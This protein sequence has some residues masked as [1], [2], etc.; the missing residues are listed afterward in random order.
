MC[1]IN[2]FWGP[3][4]RELLE[5]MMIVQRHRGP[6]DDGFLEHDVASLGFRRLSII[7]IAHGAQPMTTADGHLHIVYNG[8]VYNF[9]ELRVDLE[10]RGHE[11][12]TTCDTEVVLHAYAEWGL[13]CLKK[14]NGMWGFAVLDLRG[15]SPKLV[16]ARDHYGIKPLYYATSGQRILFASEIK[17]IL[18]DD[19][20][21][22]EV[23]EEQLYQY[24]LQG[25]FDHTESTFFKGVRQ[26]PAAGYVVIQDSGMEEGKYWEPVL[27]ENGSGD[28]A[29]FRAVFERSVQRRLIADVPVGICLSGGLDSSSICT[30]M[31]QQ[32]EAHIPDSRSLGDRLKTF[33][34]LFPNDPIDEKDYLDTVLEKTGA[35]SSTCEPT[36][37]DFIEQMEDWVW[38][39]EQPMVSSAPFAMWMVMRLASEQVTVVLDG[40][41][42]DELLGGYDHYPYV[43]LRQ[44]WS[45]GE[46]RKLA[47]ETWALRDIVWPLVRRRLLERRHKAPVKSWLKSDF[48]QGKQ[49]A[50][51]P[52]VLNNLKLRL[53]Q[54]F[55]IYSLPPLLRYEDR[56]SMAHSIEARL[57]FLDQE[58]VEHVLNLPTEAIISGG[59]TRRILREALKGTLPDKVYRRRK[60]I[61]FTTPEF[62]WYRRRRATL[63]SLMR[64]PSFANRQYWNAGPIAEAFRQACA[65]EIEESMFFWRVINAEIWLRIFFD[66]HVRRPSELSLERGFSGRGDRSVA[67]ANEYASDLLQRCRANEGHHLFLQAGSDV[68]ARIPM[69][70][71]VVG[72][73][74]D[75]ISEISTCLDALGARGV[76]VE[77]GDLLLVSEKTVS[78]SQGRSF[79]VVEVQVGRLARLLSRFVGRF[80]TGVGLAH[81]VTTQLAI[82]EAGAPRILA[83]AL[84][85]A[86]TRP[87]GVH[88]LFYRVAGNRVNAID[89]PSK[90][91]LPPYDKWASL[92]PLDCEGEAR[93]LA[94]GL[95]ERYGKRVEVAII[96]ASDLGADVFAHTS[97]VDQ[98]TVLA[99]IADNPLGQSDEQTPFGLVRKMPVGAGSRVLT[100]A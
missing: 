58:L 77:D 76:E 54:D 73:G 34:A 18:Q 95:R 81:P 25:F 8:E 86:V 64:S 29:E 45:G 4:D 48:V 88:G 36:A 2:G 69:R 60:K 56:A 68:F 3:R 41:G 52:R 59:W 91:N 62:R 26:V 6:D 22:R 53:L 13:D 31:A 72:V 55:L 74:D 9:R 46:Y 21:A 92:A 20:F 39:I 38:H 5:S 50:P 11:F 12:H 94:D 79:P 100:P 75:L 85:T 78:I 17:A 15:T 1:G 71:K 30:V 99:V 98:S 42:G 35:A 97:G 23:D 63:Q 66:D 19:N 40:Q 93:K 87:F 82:D 37:D 33:S 10:A 57:P 61:G 51:D 65:G 84:A 83:A 47:C 49:A 90:D 32:L 44:L 24:L 27:T 67:A 80:G 28:P 14:F 16:L 7:D 96:D 43:Y 89:G 70:S